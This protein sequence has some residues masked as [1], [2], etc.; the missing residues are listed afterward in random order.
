MK[1]VKL[2]LIAV[3]SFF[4]GCVQNQP[5]VKINPNNDI[6]LLKNYGITGDNLIFYKKYYYFSKTES[7]GISINKLDKN[8]NLISKKI[9]KTLIEP[10]KY[11]INNDHF[12]LLGYDNIKQKPVIL[13]FSLNSFSLL[14]TVYLGKKYSMPA[15][16]FVDKNNIYSAINV[17]N[18]KTKSDIYIYKNTSVFSKIASTKKELAKFITPYD[19]K[20]LVVGNI[21]FTND[22]ILIILINKN[23]KI[24]KA[25]RIDLGMDDY[26]NKVS[27]K[28]DNIIIYAVSTDNMGA[29]TDYILTIDKNLNVLKSKKNLE[30]KELP[31]KFRT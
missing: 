19:N 4:I 12:Y 9:I 31:I 27:I 23:G 14:K 10:K 26:V 15:D 24:T 18:K 6:K 25:R 16:F 3:I 21:S 1:N 20:I 17:F 28:N 5:Q 7:N 13:D 8:Y 30:F 2:I 29:E 11:L 22:D